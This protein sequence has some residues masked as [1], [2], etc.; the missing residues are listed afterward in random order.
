MADRRSV[1]AAA[2]AVAESDAANG[3]R[4]GTVTKAQ[5]ASVLPSPPAT[6]E[7]G[8]NDKAA[9]P[10]R[11]AVSRKLF[12]PSELPTKDSKLADIR[13]FVKENG[14]DVKVYVGGKQRRTKADIVADIYAILELEL[15]QLVVRTEVDPD[16]GLDVETIEHE[17]D[18]IEALVVAYVEYSDRA[19]D[20]VQEAWIDTETVQDVLGYTSNYNP[21]KYQMKNRPEMLKGRYI[22]GRLCLNRREFLFCLN[23]MRNAAAA[24]ALLETLTYYFDG[25]GLTFLSYN[26][27]D[28][29][30]SR[31]KKATHRFSS[32][33]QF[34]VGTY[35][36]DLYF[37][38]ERL[39]VECDEHNH[40]AY[41]SDAEAKREAFLEST[42]N[43]RF[44]RF[45]PHCS[46]V[47]HKLEYHIGEIL[48]L[49]Y[50]QD[51]VQDERC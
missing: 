41:R 25:T 18:G 12:G 8:T 45:N 26:E 43:C 27:E 38:S 7:K 3:P 29:W 33:T 44:Y 6:P 49:L 9:H 30:I 10:V 15:A 32:E 40:A 46:N 35:R 42:L 16:T 11:T 19:A 50:N 31:I 23:K 1:G 39:A 48:H 2:T 47:N 4:S 37:P 51:A 34:S 20:K 24:H 17:Y 5:T 13:S 14:L 36:I 22:R 28:H 21:F